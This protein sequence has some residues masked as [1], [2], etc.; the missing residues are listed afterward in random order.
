[1][2]TF[3]V[4]SVNSIDGGALVVASEEEEVLG[5]FDLVRHQQ[6]NTLDGHFSSI[7]VIAQEQV[8]GISGE[9][10]VFKQFNKI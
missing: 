7:N 9:S 3:V 6:A 2:S 8:V 10:S 5:M 4:E 1:M